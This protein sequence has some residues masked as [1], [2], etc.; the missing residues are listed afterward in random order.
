MRVAVNFPYFVPYAGWF[1]LFAS[2]DLFVSF[3]CVPFPRRGFVHRNR[4]PDHRGE[5]GWLTLPVGHAPRDTCI[6]D[7]RLAGDAGPRI[8]RAAQRFPALAGPRAADDPLAR[9][10]LDPA[11]GGALRETVEETIDLACERLGLPHERL[12]SSDLG[13]DPALR[14]EA[15][16]LALVRAV[17]G[18]EYVNA[19]GGRALYDA[20]R[21]RHHG[22]ALRFLDPWR[23]APWSI[24]HPLL[25]EPATA[26]AREIRRESLR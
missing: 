15:R 20:D 1:R 14:G 2:V 13:I 5:T 8:R 6:R 9:R 4:L 25:T 22:I 18:T 21:W 19:P 17:G 23:G 3:D 24:L 12:R 7:M 10:C 26:V 16:V 11:D